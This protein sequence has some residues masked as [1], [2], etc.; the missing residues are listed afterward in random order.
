MKRQKSFVFL[1]PLTIFLLCHGQT[2]AQNKAATAGGKTAKAGTA[3]KSAYVSGRIFDHEFEYSK[4]FYNA[5]SLMLR[6]PGVATGN[7][8]SPEAYQG[9]RITFADSQQFEGKSFKVAIDQ[10]KMQDG[11]DLKPKPTLQLYATV[12]KK[13]D[14]YLDV[15]KN[16]NPYA[17]TLNFYR[18]QNGLL[19]GFIELEILDSHTKIKGYFWASPL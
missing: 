6:G 17:M 8:I 2:L 10:D 11:N 15:V 13:A 16:K 9:I 14:H 18:R 7:P 12:G 4:A 5:N 19:P 1:L 3:T